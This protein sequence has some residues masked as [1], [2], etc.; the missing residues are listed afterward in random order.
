MTTVSRLAAAALLLTAAQAPAA[1]LKKLDRT[2]ARQPAYTSKQPRYCLLVFGPQAATRVWLV[3]DGEFLYV[4]RNGNGDLTEP[5]ERVRFPGF[6]TSGDGP[7]A[8]EREVEAGTVAEGKLRHERLRVAQKRV[9]PRLPARERWEEELQ[10]LAGGKEGALVYEVSL[11][12]EVRPGPGDPFRITGRV[13]QYAGLDGDGFLQFASSLTA[14]R[15]R[16]FSTFA[17][18]CGWACTRRSA[19]P[20]A[21]R[22]A[23]C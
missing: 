8:G 12:V 5:G 16:L 4:D 13:S 1:E 17:A 11:S 20:W 15:T 9:K 23:T 18:R 21:R 6:R 7:Y 22:D 2:I 10:A 3:A 19:S 14:R